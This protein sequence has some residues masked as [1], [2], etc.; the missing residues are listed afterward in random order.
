[1]KQFIWYNPYTNSYETGNEVDLKNAKNQC[2]HAEHFQI[3]YQLTE[4]SKR[5]ASKL[6]ESLN[7]QNT[8]KVAS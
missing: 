6:T 4:V 7:A 3:I 1:M 2:D 5:I 8:N